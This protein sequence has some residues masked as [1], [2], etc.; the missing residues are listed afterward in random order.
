MKEREDDQKRWENDREQIEKSLHQLTDK[1]VDNIIFDSEVNKW[2][3]NDSEFDSIL[4]G[5]RNVCIVIED[6]RHNL[7]GGFIGNTI[8][9]HHKIIDNSCFVFSLKK[10]G[11]INPRKFNKKENGYSYSICSDRHNILMG[12]GLKGDSFQD[13]SIFK[14]DYS[15]SG[16]CIQYAFDYGN[17]EYALC[18]KIYFNIISN[19]SSKQIVTFIFN[20]NTN[21]FLSFQN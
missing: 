10:D 9:I 5:K 21:I 6:E 15:C 11:Q 14:K 4:N 19:V 17:E 20:H 13:L 7:F 8:T 1:Q 2:N 16:R 3:Q 18:G 12:L